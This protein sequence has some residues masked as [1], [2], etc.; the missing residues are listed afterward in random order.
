MS[1]TTMIS[2][3]ITGV[4]LLGVFLLTQSGWLAFVVYLIVLF[5][6]FGWSCC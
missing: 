1:D 4:I 2:L 6:I 3:G 5:L